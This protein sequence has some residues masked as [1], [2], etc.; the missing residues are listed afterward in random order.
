MTAELSDSIVSRENS[1]RAMCYQFA[2]SRA[3][4]LAK[5]VARNQTILAIFAAVLGLMS[6]LWPEMKAWVGLFSFVVLV[7]DLCFLEEFGKAYQSMGAKIQETFDCFVLEIDE[8]STKISPLPDHEQIRGL[9]EAFISSKTAAELAKEIER[10]RNWY[11]VCVAE[12]PIAYGRLIC[13]RAN[14]SW[15]SSLR[16]NYAY[17]FFV[18]VFFVV[19]AAIIIAVA[20][21]IDSQ[22]VLMSLVLPLAPVAVKMIREGQKHLDSAKSSDRAKSILHSVWAKAM[23]KKISPNQ[24][25]AESR[26]LQDEL[27]ERRKNS[28]P[29]P[30][31]LY[32]WFKDIQEGEMQYAASELVSEVKENELV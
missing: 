22:T 23:N 8:N 16:K 9:S 19:L 13:Q 21:N 24:M 5:T 12:V 4:F 14:M 25:L 27:Y 18:T 26:K 32:F 15:D 28:P 11:P 20:T 1:D 10:L 3:Y 7:G 30:E 29:V 17:I 2:S 6:L 31:L